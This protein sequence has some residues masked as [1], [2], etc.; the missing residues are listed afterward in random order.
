MSMM[1]PLELRYLKLTL[2]QAEQK[3]YLDQKKKDAA[4]EQLLR[5]QLEL[6]KNRIL[7]K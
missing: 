3:K 4:K 7:R 2:E 5:I 6:S 1:N